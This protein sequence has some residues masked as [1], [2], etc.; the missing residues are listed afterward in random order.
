MIGSAASTA[1]QQ[2]QEE[3]HAKHADSN[4]LNAPSKCAIRCTFTVINSVGAGFLEK[5][6]ENGLAYE[7]R[8]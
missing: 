2:V 3:L 5:V 7:C 8:L 4:E 6:Y 1:R